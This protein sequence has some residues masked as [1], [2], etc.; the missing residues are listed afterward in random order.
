MIEFA[1]AVNK[2]WP[3]SSE[4]IVISRINRYMELENQIY[5]EYAEKKFW[6]IPKDVETFSRIFIFRFGKLHGALKEIKFVESCIRDFLPTVT[7]LGNFWIGLRYLF[8]LL[9]I[10]SIVTFSGGVNEEKRILDV[11]EVVG[12]WTAAEMAFSRSVLASSRFSKLSSRFGISLR[13]IVIACF[14]ST[15]IEFT[16]LICFGNIVA[17]LTQG[18]VWNVFDYLNLFIGT[19]LLYVL[20][21]PIAYI[22]SRNS[23]VW[24]D[25]RFLVSP[26]FRIF[27][28]LTPLF[29]EYH[30][31]FALFSN[32]VSYLPTNLPLLIL[33]HD[34][35]V[36]YRP[37]FTFLIILSIVST[38]WIIKYRVVKPSKWIV[39]KP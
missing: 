35:K 2:L 10:V 13:N 9:F 3:G 26:I 33:L 36:E 23:N 24:T 34:S 4:E 28:L 6:K 19:I 16:I 21:A 22:V 8:A 7:K 31:N 25:L 12:I 11:L 14:L 1:L 15:W 30:Q 32:I 17:L 5:R 18:R 27:L 39:V 29:F 20:L 38:F 37:I